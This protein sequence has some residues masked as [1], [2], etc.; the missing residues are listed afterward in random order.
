VANEKASDAGSPETRA[1]AT[2][3]PPIAGADAAAADAD[4]DAD[5]NANAAE[6]AGVD[7][8]LQTQ[9]AETS[10]LTLADCHIEQVAASCGSLVVPENPD[11]PDGSQLSLEIAVVR[12]IGTP[13]MP[14][15]IV[16]LADL[17]KAAIEDDLL[18]TQLPLMYSNNVRDLVYV[19]Q[20]GTGASNAVPCPLPSEAEMA[21]GDLSVVTT[22]VGRCAAAA[23]PNLRYYTT[24]AAADDLDRVREALGYDEI[25]LYGVGYGAVAA[26]VYLV[27]HGDHVRSA[28]LDG[29]S[30]LDVPAAERRAAIAQRSL[31]HLF[32]RCAADADC[33]AA[34]PDLAADYAKVDELLKRHPLKVAGVRTPLDRVSFAGALADLLGDTHAKTAIP[35]VIHLLATGDESAAAT[36]LA[37]AL[38][39]STDALAA[40]LL[41]RCNEPWAS[42]RPAQVARSSAGTFLAPL[43]ARTA[44]R[45]SAACRALPTAPLPADLRG[46]IHSDARVVILLG[47]EDVA[48]S[49]SAFAHAA[50]ELPNSTS[51]VFAGA[52]GDQLHSTLCARDIFVYFLDPG[53][54]SGDELDCAKT[55]GV[56]PFDTGA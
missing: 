10:G 35:R 28:F 24:A 3:A 30:L 54:L 33:H 38:E 8:A 49:P 1:A 48:S 5:A 20:R 23:G 15:P 43:E 42:L 27:R 39:R 36:D 29:G 55:D 14:D 9:A 16:Y 2:V 19:D 34:Y 51:I 26:Q 47:G 41:I 40:T 12:S 11:D 52:G 50:E 4:A 46:P 17:G 13:A 7:T 32:A 6:P 37:P 25:N 31:D 21:T 22:A 56:L 18:R 45:L 44:A 53:T